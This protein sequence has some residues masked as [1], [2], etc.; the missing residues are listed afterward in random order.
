MWV[1]LYTYRK[2]SFSPGRNF[3]HAP[4]ARSVPVSALELCVGLMYH[5]SIC[6]NSASKAV[7]LSQIPTFLRTTMITWNFKNGRLYVVTVIWVSLLERGAA[8]SRG[9]VPADPQLMSLKPPC[10]GNAAIQNMSTTELNFKHTGHKQQNLQEHSLS[11]T[12]GSLYT[13]QNLLS[14]L[15]SYCK[16]CIASTCQ[17][18]VNV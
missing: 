6:S 2:R 13:P 4:G 1:Y 11:A 8:L 14:L 3:K 15:V 16:H 5:T 10:F 17:D 12:T 7:E 18:T 9:T